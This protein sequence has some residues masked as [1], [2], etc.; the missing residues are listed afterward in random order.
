MN[1]W[2]A[3]YDHETGEIGDVTHGSPGSLI[4]HR[5]PYVDLPDYRVDWAL[6]H[7]VVDDQLVP[8]PA[9]ALAALR[10]ELAMADLRNKRMALLKTEVDPI[11]GSQLRWAALS[12]EQQTALAAYRQALLDWPST[13]PDPLNPTP[14]AEPEV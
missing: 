5:R 6:T 9:E 3:Y 2:V 14:P 10:L 4:A 12:A 11:A 13:E 1:R 8:R 7:I